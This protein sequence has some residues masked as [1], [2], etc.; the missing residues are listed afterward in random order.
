METTLSSTST[1]RESKGTNSSIQSTGPTRP[2]SASC[3]TQQRSLSVDLYPPSPDDPSL[4][5]AKTTGTK[6]A[7]EP[8]SILRRTCIT[9]TELTDLKPTRVYIP[10]ADT[11]VREIPAN[12]NYTT[13]S[14]GLEGS[15]S[16]PSRAAESQRDLKE[17]RV[18]WE[19][20]V[21]VY[22]LPPRTRKESPLDEGALKRRGLL[23]EVDVVLNRG[24]PH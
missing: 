1:D 18:T 14:L 13:E 10:S 11:T 12:A 5:E 3:E 22:T 19:S 21:R 17:Q 4:A 6:S 7:T 24:S 20:Q 15:V 16:T 23:A 8:C 9:Q 2:A